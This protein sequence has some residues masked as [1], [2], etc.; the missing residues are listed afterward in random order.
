MEKKKSMKNFETWSLAYRRSPS[1]IPGAESNHIWIRR[2]GG[3]GA[4]DGYK[5][6][7]QSM[8]TTH[9]LLYIRHVNQIATPQFEGKVHIRVKA[10]HTTG[11]FTSLLQGHM[12]TFLGLVL[13]LRVA[14]Q[15]C[16]GVLEG[17]VSTGA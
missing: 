13:C 12:G 11:W 5:I 14:Q 3:G 1:L 10:G 6:S 8:L 17:F 15:C 2:A 16:K 9:R 7:H 4:R